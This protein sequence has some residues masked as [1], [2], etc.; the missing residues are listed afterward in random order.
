MKLSTILLLSGVISQPQIVA[1]EELDIESY[2]VLEHGICMLLEGE[3]IHPSHYLKYE[4]IAK[5]IIEQIEERGSLLRDNTLTPYV[6]DGKLDVLCT[7]YSYAKEEF[8]PHL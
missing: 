7:I 2:R 8:E 6:H 3:I 5:S 1:K 4:R